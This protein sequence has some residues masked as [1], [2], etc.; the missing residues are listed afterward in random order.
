MMRQSQYERMLQDLQETHQRLEALLDNFGRMLGVTES[1]FNGQEGISARLRMLEDYL[2]DIRTKCAY[3]CLFGF[4]GGMLAGL[5]A[6]FF[7]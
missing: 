4:C 5:T 6:F 3:S 7:M 1:L 2:D